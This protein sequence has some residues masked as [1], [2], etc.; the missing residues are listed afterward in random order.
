MNQGNVFD[1][2]QQDKKLKDLILEARVIMR[3]EVINS[4]LRLKILLKV[5]RN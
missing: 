2:Y 3:E 5:L 1:R 4:D